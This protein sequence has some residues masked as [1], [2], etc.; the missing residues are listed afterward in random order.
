MLADAVEAA[1][2]SLKKPTIARLDK[3]IW[4]IIM[5][6]FNAGGLSQS[7]LTFNDLDKIKES[8]V[9]LLAGYFHTRIE[10]P[11]QKEAAR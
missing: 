5:E 1:S 2:R 8:F 4:E 11:K 10:Y 6:R 7:N 3:S 9:Q